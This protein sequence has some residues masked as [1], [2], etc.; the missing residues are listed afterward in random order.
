MMNSRTIINH[1][2]PLLGAHY[3]ALS[4][5]ISNAQEDILYADTMR[6]VKK[7]MGIEDEVVMHGK[8]P[9]AR[10]FF[11]SLTNISENAD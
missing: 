2:S 7:L 3:K 10:E 4:Q 6:Q 8:L 9:T 11:M 5:C 1:L